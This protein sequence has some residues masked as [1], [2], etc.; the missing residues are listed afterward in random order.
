MTVSEIIPWSWISQCYRL[1]IQ[2]WLDWPMSCPL[3]KLARWSLRACAFCFRWINLWA[4]DW[5]I[6]IC[7]LDRMVG[8]W[9]LSPA[10]L[11]IPRIG[12]RILARKCSYSHISQ[13]G[14]APKTLARLQRRRVWLPERQMLSRCRAESRRSCK[15]KRQ[16][17]LLRSEKVELCMCR[18]EEANICKILSPIKLSTLKKLWTNA[19]SHKGRALK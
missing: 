10:G 3:R 11:L 4:G 14:S 18:P 1:A 5:W 15:Q 6:E 19:G 12:D 13:N 2:T 17:T 16:P 7:P 8:F 9:G